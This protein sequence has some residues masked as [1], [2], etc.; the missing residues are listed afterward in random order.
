MA[1][2]QDLALVPK[3]GRFQILSRSDTRIRSTSR[4]K[5]L[6]ATHTS[7]PNGKL[8]SLSALLLY[9]RTAPLDPSYNALRALTAV[10]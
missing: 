9:E 4:L 5:A 10:V 7:G 1:L 2:A 3:L 6:L 8:L